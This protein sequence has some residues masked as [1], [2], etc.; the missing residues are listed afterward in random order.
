METDGDK[1]V[2]TYAEL[3]RFKGENLENSPSMPTFF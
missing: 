3:M 1:A 2:F